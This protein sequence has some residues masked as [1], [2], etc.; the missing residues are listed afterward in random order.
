[1]FFFSTQLLLSFLHVAVKNMVTV[2]KITLYSYP[3]SNT[4]FEDSTKQK[5]SSYNPENFMYFFYFSY[6]LLESSA[7]VKQKILTLSC[8]G[9]CF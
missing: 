8:E 5:S 2:C 4:W 3:V 9:Y 7:F 6:L 1:M